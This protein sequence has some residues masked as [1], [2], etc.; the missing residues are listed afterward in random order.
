MHVRLRNTGQPGETPLGGLPAT[1]EHAKVSD[2]PPPEFAK[3][4]TTPVNP[5]PIGNRVVLGLI[6]PRLES[7]DCLV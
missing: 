2:E 7:G 1:N 5:I 6:V 3:V 4:H